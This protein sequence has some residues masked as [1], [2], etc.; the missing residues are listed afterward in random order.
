MAKWKVGIGVI[1]MGWMG[2]VH[3]RSYRNIPMRFPDSE[4]TPH[5][6]ICSDN[7]E[8]RAK[9]AQTMFGF[10][11]TTTDW[12]RVIEHPDVEVINIAT[13][14]K[15][16]LEIVEAA[17]AAGKHILCEKPV[18]R[19]PDETA[20]IERLAREAGVITFVGFNYRWTPLIQHLHNLI[21][22][23]ELGDLTHYRGRF[24]SMYGSNPYGVLSWR[25]D[26]ETSGYGV[27]GDIMAHVV[28]MAL[29][30]VGDIKRVASTKHTFITERPL[31]V[32]GRGTHYAVG[33]LGDETGT[34]TNEDY[35][36]AM[37]EFSNGTRGTFEA[38]RTI[39]GPKNQFAFE[40]NGTKGAAMWDFERM[41]ELQLYQPGDDNKHDGFMRLVGGEQYPYH[42][43]FNPGEGSGIGYEDLKIIEAYEFLKSVKEKTQQSPGFS[44]ALAVAEVSAAMIRSWK[45]ERWENVT[46]LRQE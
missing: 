24:F 16:H 46:P 28:D 40:L 43:R 5:L 13:P 6:V 33:Q 19:T 45:S 4:I 26:F 7:V 14:N 18:G 1:G 12:R 39:Y 8:A 36:G 15:L 41:N 25:F 10:E 23:G 35:V 42:G 27:L 3:T 30:L 20:A 32:P 11:D 38:S 9:Q 2:Q 44:E 37:I 21:Q 34:V 29:F 17:A 31:I 22:R